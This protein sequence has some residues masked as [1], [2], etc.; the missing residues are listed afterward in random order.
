VFSQGKKKKKKKKNI[1]ETVFTVASV[2]H[3]L[4]PLHKE[5]AEAQEPVQTCLKPFPYRLSW[6]AK[7]E[8]PIPTL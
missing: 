1:Y 6:R 4:V 8:Q 7:T 3:G 2:A 5:P